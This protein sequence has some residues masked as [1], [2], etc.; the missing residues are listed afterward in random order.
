MWEKK[1]ACLDYIII[2]IILAYNIVFTN[3][4]IIIV[5]Y[6]SF[7]ICLF[8]DFPTGPGHL[9]FYCKRAPLLLQYLISRG[10]SINKCDPALIA[11]KRLS[12][13]EGDLWV[14]VTNRD[15][16]TA[17]ICFGSYNGSDDS[18]VRT[19]VGS[20]DSTGSLKGKVSFNFLYTNCF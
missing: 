14:N 10:K 6:I 4:T 17:P 12:R 18:G 1:C 7:A 13:S 15:S 19:S 20:D 9:H 16:K 11:S 8:S 5:V 3:P 2:I